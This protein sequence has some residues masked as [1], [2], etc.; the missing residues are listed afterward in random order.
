MEPL[1]VVVIVL[2]VIA[3]LV[4]RLV[5]FINVVRRDSEKKNESAGNS[6]DNV[7]R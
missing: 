3:Y 7:G 2:T 5:M 6:P 1:A 4:N